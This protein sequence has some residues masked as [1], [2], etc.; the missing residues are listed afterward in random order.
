MRAAVAATLLIVVSTVQAACPTLY[1]SGWTAVY[2][3]NTAELCNTQYVSVYD[4]AQSKVV[5]TSEYLV[6]GTAIG[7]LNR[8]GAFRKDSRVPSS[9]SL[10]LYTNAGY[11]K[12]H[13]VPSDD[14]S[15]A[16]EMRETYLNTNIVPQSPI[17]NRGKWKKLE[18]Y[19]RLQAY[20]SG[21]SVHVL[22][23]PIYTHP[24]K[25]MSS[26]VPVPTGIWKITIRPDGVTRAFFAPNLDNTTVQE[27]SNVNW[28]D[29]IQQQLK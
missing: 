17:L 18:R 13:M 6:H 25:L 10:S 16:A 20:K 9:P 27:F 7:S 21:M 4:V 14:A 23:I 26:V 11:D 1:P 19:V 3:T 29:L 24:P 12:G 5:F 8:I 22:T 15:N 28:V 2:P